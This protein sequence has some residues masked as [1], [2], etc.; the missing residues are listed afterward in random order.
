MN[1]TLISITQSQHEHWMEIF[2]GIP[3][4]SRSRPR[5]NKTLDEPK[6]R[7]AGNHCTLEPRPPRRSDS[8][9]RRGAKQADIIGQIKDKVLVLH[10]PINNYIDQFNSILKLNCHHYQLYP[11]QSN[12]GHKLCW[13]QFPSTVTHIVINIRKRFIYLFLLAK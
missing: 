7:S 9:E 10:W 11:L 4:T 3:G 6:P 1:L 2:E 13:V 12:A 8:E 5:A